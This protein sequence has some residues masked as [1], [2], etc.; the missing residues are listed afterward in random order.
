MIPVKGR[1]E[2]DMQDG[3]MECLTVVM[4]PRMIEA[5]LTHQMLPPMI[6]P[7]EAQHVREFLL[8]DYLSDTLVAIARTSGWGWHCAQSLVRTATVEDVDELIDQE[9]MVRQT[10]L[11]ADRLEEK[12]V[13]LKDSFPLVNVLAIHH[14]YTHTCD[15]TGEEIIEHSA[16]QRKALMSHPLFERSVKKLQSEPICR[17]FFL[18]HNTDSDS[19]DLLLK[20][21]A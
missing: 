20:M 21:G 2:Q 14:L 16:T 19:V 17:A 3:Q 12:G 9:V 11:V 15:P 10:T 8:Y 4:T 7:E 5:C 1:I 6:I 13:N 18:L